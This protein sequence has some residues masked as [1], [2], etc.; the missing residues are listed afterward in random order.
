MPTT[1]QEERVRWVL[2]V[3]RK[4]LK[5]KDV[6]RVCPHSQRSLERWVAL[7]KKYGEEGL[8]PAINQTEESSA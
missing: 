6:A 1:I 7:Y 2:P 3:V 4:E 5:L 8:T